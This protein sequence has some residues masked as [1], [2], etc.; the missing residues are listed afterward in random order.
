MY[1][2]EGRRKKEGVGSSFY[3]GEGGGSNEDES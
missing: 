1:V 2:D 3:W